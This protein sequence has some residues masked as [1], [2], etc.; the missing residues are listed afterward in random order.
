LV[1]LVCIFWLISLIVS[2]FS[3]SKIGSASSAEEKSLFGSYGDII[4]NSLL[5]FFGMT[6]SGLLIYWIVYG[7]QTLT[8]RSGILSF[9]LNLVIIIAV[10]AIVYQIIAGTAF[11]RNSP[12][13]RL[14]VN[15]VLYIPCILVSLVN[16]LVGLF[17]I[18]K[19]YAPSMPTSLLPSFKNLKLGSVGKRQPRAHADTHVHM[20]ARAPQVCARTCVRA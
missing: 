9:I 7:V 6:F 13:L 8:S 5:L 11:Y 1:I 10:L 17:G 16:N 19:S 18:A 4:R 2:L 20:H 15:T 12:L 14:V 3:T